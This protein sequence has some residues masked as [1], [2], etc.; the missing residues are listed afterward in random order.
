MEKSKDYGFGKFE[1]TGTASDLSVK[2]G[3]TSL[4]G[5][6]IN[7]IYKLAIASKFE[8]TVTLRSHMAKNSEWGAIAYL[9]HSQYGTNGKK[10]EQNTDTN[11]ST[12]G[13]NNKETIY[14]TNKTQSTTHN[15]DRSI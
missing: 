8:E 7:Q 13:N 4:R 2:P 10:V 9:G 15:R 14:T 1:T 12:G 6:T 3:V 5:R 11:Y